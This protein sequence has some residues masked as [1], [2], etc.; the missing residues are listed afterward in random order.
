MLF[1]SIE[2]GTA[3]NARESENYLPISGADPGFQVRG[4]A[5]KKLRRAEGGSNIFGVFRVKNHDFTP[6]NHIFSYCGG[7][8][9]FFGGISCQKSRFTPKNH[10]PCIAITMIDNMEYMHTTCMYIITTR[11][12]W[13]ICII[14][15]LRLGGVRRWQNLLENQGQ[16]LQD[17][18]QLHLGLFKL[19]YT[20][21]VDSFERTR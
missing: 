5:L 19:I 12:Y 16:I 14:L 17:Y 10:I 2:T 6:K 15:H 11:K 3:I 13:Y 21:N 1:P 4:G 20:Q 18:N 8:H 7:R 9:K